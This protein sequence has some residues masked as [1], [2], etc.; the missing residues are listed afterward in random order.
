MSP[1]LVW[2]DVETFASLGVCACVCA[3][4]RTRARLWGVLILSTVRKVVHGFNG[5]GILFLPF[6]TPLL[7]I[8]F[9]Y[10]PSF[11]RSFLSSLFGWGRFS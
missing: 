11:L 1:L 7:P 6:L 9:L 3:R 8:S 4:A 5:S 2:F 10:T